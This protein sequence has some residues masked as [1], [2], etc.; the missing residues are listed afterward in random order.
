M[1]VSYFQATGHHV[2]QGGS[3]QKLP[4]L[5]YVDDAVLI[6]EPEAQV[7]NNITRFEGVPRTMMFKINAIKSLVLM[8]MKNGHS[9]CKIDYN[10]D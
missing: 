10:W 5:L 2:S 7:G 4:Q 1:V 6:V 9:Q 8:F 3:E